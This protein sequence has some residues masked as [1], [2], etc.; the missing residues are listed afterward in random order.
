[1]G[2]YEMQIREKAQLPVG[3]RDYCAHLIIPYNE[4]VQT[5]RPFAAHNCYGKYHTW[6]EC[7]YEVTKIQ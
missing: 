7:E 4:C 6:V 3:L 2:F 1:M 5:H